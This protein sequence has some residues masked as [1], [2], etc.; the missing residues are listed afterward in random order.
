MGDA[1]YQA[2]SDA[3]LKRAAAAQKLG[4][5]L[6]YG[7][8]NALTQV[9]KGIPSGGGTGKGSKQLAMALDPT[10]IYEMQEEAA[11]LHQANL[12]DRE[13]AARSRFGM[14]PL[15]RAVTP[16]R[17]REGL[18]NVVA[19]RLGLS[20][21]TV[22]RPDTIAG[23]AELVRS[24]DPAARSM[25]SAQG[26]NPDI[27]AE[28]LQGMAEEARVYQSQLAARLGAR[29]KEKK[30]LDLAGRTTLM[31]A[32]IAQ[33]G[34]D[35]ENADLVAA[36]LAKLPD[37]AAQQAIKELG[38]PTKFSHELALAKR[39]SV[40]TIINKYVGLPDKG[41]KGRSGGGSGAGY[42]GQLGQE[43][44][45]VR[46]NIA[47]LDEL[48]VSQG[49]LT[50]EQQA[51]RDAEQERY[52][53][54]LARY[55]DALGVDSASG[56]KIPMEEAVKKMWADGADYATAFDMI[57]KAYGEADPA[58]VLFQLGTRNEWNSRSSTGVKTP[59]TPSGFNEWYRSKDSKGKAD[60]DDKMGA[61]IRSEIG[62]GTTKQKFL[63]LVSSKNKILS[64]N[65]AQKYIGD[66]YD[67]FSGTQA[68]EPAQ[69]PQRPATAAQPQ[70]EVQPE[71]QTE[72][73]VVP[74]VPQ[75][76][77]GTTRTVV[78]Q[79]VSTPQAPSAVAAED[80]SESKIASQSTESI[81]TY[82][83]ARE[84]EE[85][86]RS[87]SADDWAEL[88]MAPRNLPTGPF[89]DAD[90]Y[91]DMSLE[92]GDSK[93]TGYQA[94]R[95]KAQELVDEANEIAQK[96][97][98]EI[99]FSSDESLEELDSARA[100]IHAGLAHQLRAQGM[101]LVTGKEEGDLIRAFGFFKPG[102]QVEGQA[103]G[104]YLS[105]P[106][107]EDVYQ[108]F[109]YVVDPKTGERIYLQGFLGRG[110]NTSRAAGEVE[111]AAQL[112]AQQLSKLQA[113]LQR[114]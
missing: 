31:R 112:R 68:V 110:G 9:M 1:A 97:V 30:A 71:A 41:S 102:L 51:K 77:P 114:R 84:R 39:R 3:N 101:R 6:T 80:P 27:T 7:G 103:K 104:G 10:A 86:L 57:K 21:R 12:A 105:D 53:L 87:G 64:S 16:Q 11:R 56:G 54:V 14:S 83:Q 42:A 95:T 63:G 74:G 13:A 28:E 40:K 94:R 58:S 109:S 46:G 33:M 29:G 93:V 52:E 37:D 59:G 79:D 113:D 85:G 107:Q 50:A 23:L 35:A 106:S 75:V 66:L 8:G 18:R 92:R 17:E 43:V 2:R 91:L 26:I 4:A 89:A 55:Y 62:K 5:A 108:Q 44:R 88:D 81:D 73:A 72:A 45:S 47:K 24:R 82:R 96:I 22:V 61:L 69:M 60:F 99:D 100:K 49:G 36:E 65:E 20:E 76:S 38:R 90:L 67:M 98:S 78:R 15:A 111:A 70:P 32:R 48:K 19:E 25:L 34:Y